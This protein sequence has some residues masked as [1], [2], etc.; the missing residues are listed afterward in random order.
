MTDGEKPPEGVA[1]ALAEFNAL[2]AEIT[3]SLAAQQ[4]FVGV[5]LTSIGLL[6]GFA[7]KDADHKPLLFAVPPVALVGCLLYL[8]LVHRM[9]EIG[10]Y[11]RTKVWIFIQDK[12]LYPHSWEHHTNVELVK[13][14]R[15][16]VKNFF[17]DGSV[18]LIL[19]LAA[20]SALI[21]GTDAQPATRVSSHWMALLSTILTFVIPALYGW[22]RRKLS[23]P[24]AKTSED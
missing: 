8:S 5:A 20:L 2:R 4:A 19:F 3:S 16:L 14:R 21:Y 7:L 24:V 9:F 23:N 12:T 15:R 6:W 11:I 1:A 17:F 18:P 22:Y 10:D 13:P